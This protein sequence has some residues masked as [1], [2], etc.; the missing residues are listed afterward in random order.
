MPMY[1]KFICS[2]KNYKF[3][4]YILKTKNQKTMFIK[5]I[6][7]D[8]KVDKAE[9]I[10]EKEDL[11]F[12]KFMFLPLIIKNAPDRDAIMEDVPNSSVVIME[13]FRPTGLIPWPI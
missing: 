10:L 1:K 8:P 12:L 4:F 11:S 7:T 5:K 3:F 9:S 13:D 2:T 6:S